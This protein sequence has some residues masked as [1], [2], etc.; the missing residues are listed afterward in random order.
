MIHIPLIKE[1]IKATP[2]KVD[3]KLIETITRLSQTK[4][5]KDFIA[6]HNTIPKLGKKK[7]GGGFKKS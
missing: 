4:E 2:S 3:P 7:A 1:T 5:W 6:K